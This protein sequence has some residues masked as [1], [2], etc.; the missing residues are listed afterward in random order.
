MAKNK[1]KQKNNIKEAQGKY[2]FANDQLGENTESRY[3][4]LKQDKKAGKKSGKK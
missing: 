4:E 2:E 3:E 1:N